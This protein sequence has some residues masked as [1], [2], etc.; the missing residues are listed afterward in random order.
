MNVASYIYQ[1]PSPSAMQ[2]G[3]LDP[4]SVKE[5][6]KK[7]TKDSSLDTTT[8]IQKEAQ[9]FEVAQTSEVAPSVDSEYLLDVYA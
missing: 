2:V 5:E 9:S 7:E 4:S 3:R 6:P 1:S 8:Q